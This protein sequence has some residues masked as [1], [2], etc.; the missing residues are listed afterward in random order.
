MTV[1]KRNE[2][3]H[4]LFWLNLRHIDLPPLFCCQIIALRCLLKRQAIAELLQ[5]EP[6]IAAALGAEA[7]D[8]YPLHLSPY[9]L[10]EI[11]PREPGIK[12][13]PISCENQ[14]TVFS[15]TAHHAKARVAKG[16]TWI[17]PIGAGHRKTDPQSLR[18]EREMTERRRLCALLKRRQHAAMLRA[19]G[20]ENE[21]GGFIIPV[22][23]E[24]E[25]SKA[26]NGVGGAVHDPITRRASSIGPDC[27]KELSFGTI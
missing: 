12:L 16:M 15:D 19:W 26:G 13:F 8:C 27:F 4:L 2:P 7:L 25:S 21:E 10:V 9:S 6:R 11:K 20:S 23:F 1:S 18:A 5:V 17:P 3:A 14:Y 22:N 24:A